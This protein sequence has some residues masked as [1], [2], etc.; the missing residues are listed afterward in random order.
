MTRWIMNYKKI[1]LESFVIL[2]HHEINFFILIDTDI[3]ICFYIL[4]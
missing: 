4:S 3:S 1:E 2:E